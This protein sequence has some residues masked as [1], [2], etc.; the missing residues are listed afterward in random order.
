LTTNISFEDGACNGTRL[1]FDEIVNQNSRNLLRCRIMNG[2]SAGKVILINRI[3]VI[4]AGSAVSGG[5]G[6]PWPWVRRAFPVKLA[7][8]CTIN[9]SQ[10]QTLD[11]VGVILTKP[12]FTHGQTYVAASRV[13]DAGSVCFLIPK[14]KEDRERRL[15]RNVVYHEVLSTQ[16][17][18]PPAPSTPA[19]SLSHP[20]CGMVPAEEGSLRAK[21]VGCNGLPPQTG[22]EEQLSPAP[23]PTVLASAPAAPAD[24][25]P[26]PEDMQWDNEDMALDMALDIHDADVAAAAEAGFLM[27][28]DD[29]PGQGPFGIGDDG[30]LSPAPAPSVLALAPAPA[31]YLRGPED[32]QWANDQDMALDGHDAE[33]AAAIEA[34]FLMPTLEW[35]AM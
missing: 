30:Q 32:V 14:A 8:C 15:T 13:G 21:M 12:V 5:R 11:M 18:D 3:D 17:G 34:G 19:A 7:F 16:V 24:Y 29:Q 22:Q 23:A 2:P 27:H 10:G 20:D 31:D 25:L 4:Q 1:I 6:L 35:P 33:V 9:K 28:E 26:G